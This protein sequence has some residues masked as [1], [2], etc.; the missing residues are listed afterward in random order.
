MI[1]SQKHIDKLYID[2]AKNR[3]ENKSPLSNLKGLSLYLDSAF[4]HNLIVDEQAQETYREVNKFLFGKLN[5]R[6]GKPFIQ[7]SR[8]AICD[9][10]F[11]I[12]Y[13]LAARPNA[14][15]RVEKAESDQK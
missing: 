3:S 9:L 1:E 11:T 12:D 4:P 2:F 10:E 13:I 6:A 5:K 15:V 7:Y 14:Y 8:H